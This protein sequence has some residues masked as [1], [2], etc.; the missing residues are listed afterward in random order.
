[1]S[2]MPAYVPASRQYWAIAS[3]SNTVG[4]ISTARPNCQS[5]N[6]GLMRITLLPPLIPTDLRSTYSPACHSS[7]TERGRVYCRSASCCS[8]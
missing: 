1:M 4:S 7:S 2:Q 5:V 8:G 6:I 3:A